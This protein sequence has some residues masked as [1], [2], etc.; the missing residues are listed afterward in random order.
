MLLGH[1]YVATDELDKAL[2]C[3]RGASRLDA[4][5]FNCWYG[6]GMIYFKQERFVLLIILI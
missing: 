3:F 5:R 4:S 1:E 6:I 2:R